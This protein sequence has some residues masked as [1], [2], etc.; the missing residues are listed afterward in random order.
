MSKNRIQL[1]LLGLVVAIIAGISTIYHRGIYTVWSA[2]NVERLSANK[3]YELLNQGELV[4]IDARSTREFN[5]SHLQGAVQYSPSV[6]DT[7]D[8][9]Q[10]VLVYCTVSIRSNSLAKEMSEKGFT[11]IYDIKG[12]LVSWI[13]D[14]KDLVNADNQMTDTIH[15]YSKW[16]APFV[17][18]GTAVY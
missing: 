17:R 11:Q 2:G 14:Q 5:V 16:V 9:S 15:T 3:A 12:G 10:P 4:V 8:P 6:L 13:N 18:K 1:L 7:L